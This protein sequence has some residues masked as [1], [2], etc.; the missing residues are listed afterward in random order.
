[1]PSTIGATARQARLILMGTALLLT[2]GMGMRQSF[3]LFLGPV[4][5]DLALTASDFTLAL[6]AF[7]V[8][9]AFEVPLH[10]LMTPAHHQRHA[11]EMM[12]HQRQFLSMP[13]HR[14]EGDGPARSY[15]IWGATAAMLRNLYHFLA[16]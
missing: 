10:F 11:F 3:G 4:T 7:E 15:F 5:H 2:L 9:E 1:M 6:D 13:W 12:G 14:A 8:A 16:V